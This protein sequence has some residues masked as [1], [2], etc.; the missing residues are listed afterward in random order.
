M[1]DPDNFD[2]W[3]KHPYHFWHEQDFFRL[4]QNSNKGL[5]SFL[6]QQHIMHG[7]GRQVGFIFYDKNSNQYLNSKDSMKPFIIHFAG[8]DAKKSL[9]IR[10]QYGISIS[11]CMES[12]VN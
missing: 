1:I 4:T 5:F 8:S 12:Y 2:L 7:C 3:F 9:P 6:S 11:E 10:D